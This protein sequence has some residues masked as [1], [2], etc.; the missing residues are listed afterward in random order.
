MVAKV[1]QQVQSNNRLDKLMTPAQVARR[2]F[3]SGLPRKI[4]SR[5]LSSLEALARTMELLDRFRNEMEY[6]KAQGLKGVS[7][8]DVQAALVFFQP[9]SKGKEHILAQVEIVPEPAKLGSFCDKVIALDKPVF[10]GLLFHQHDREAEK[11]GDAKQ[12]NVIFGCEFTK[13]HDATARLLAAREQQAKGG[14]GK[15]AN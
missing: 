3:K 1:V 9:R 8:D 2:K 14:F 13:A 6:L 11:A 15:T 5:E 4:E 12:A 7:K 10:L